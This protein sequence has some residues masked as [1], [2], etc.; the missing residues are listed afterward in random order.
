MLNKIFHQSIRTEVM[1]IVVTNDEVSFIMLKDKLNAT[2]GNLFIH[3]VKLE[4]AGYIKSTKHKAKKSYTTYKATPD[5]ITQFYEY[6]REV[7]KIVES[8]QS[9]RKIK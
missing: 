1:A 8:I 2:F 3:L 5:G 4:K 9:I 6:I 7:E